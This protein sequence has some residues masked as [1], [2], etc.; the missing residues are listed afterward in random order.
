MRAVYVANRLKEILP[1]YTDDFSTILS[2]SSLTRS[3]TTITCTTSTNHGLTTND[4]VTI[5]GAKE[6]I[7]LSGITFSNGIAMATS[8]S[9]HK[10]S[11]P[12]L[13]SP[14]NLPLYVEISGATGYNG[15]WELVSVPTNLTFTFKVTGSPS[16]VSGGFLLLEDQDG[17][18]GYKQIT[19]TGATTFTYQT[20]GSMQSPAQ[21]TVEVSCLTRI[22]YAATAQRISD[23]YS[24]NTGGILQ[25]WAFVVMSQN[26]AFRNDTVVGDPSSAKKRNESYW[27]TLQQDFSVYV[28]I[29]STTSTLGGNT[30]DTAK[31]YLQP[32]VK[33]LA[34][35]IFES[36]FNEGE[37]QPCVFAGD[38]A[39]DYIEATYT[40]RFDFTVQNI[41]QTVDTAEFSNGRPLELIDGTFSDKDL[42]YYVNTRS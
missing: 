29:P 24:A 22:D 5:R 7:A 3:S 2:V 1:K 38:E 28:V 39:D 37:S 23:Y 34:N 17:Y 14:E 21:G 32:L 27:Y 36:D 30:A 25:T 18:N 35:F 11:D 15:T 41:V 4:Y 33:C 10:L 8:S 40:H 20:S 9:D 26:R 6:P 19:V 13:F 12:S 16:N 31:S 42:D